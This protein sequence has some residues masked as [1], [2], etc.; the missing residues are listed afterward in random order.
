M[1][2]LRR[3]ANDQPQAARNNGVGHSP[4]VGTVGEVNRPKH[5]TSGGQVPGWLRAAFVILLTSLVILALAAITLLYF[6][7]THEADL[8][9]SKRQ[10]AIFL[11]NGQVYFGKI[12][13]L[14][15]Q[16]VNLT[17]IY[18]LN[19]QTNSDEAADKQTPNLSLVKL[20]CEL[21]G[22]QD[23]MIINRQQ[24]SF[25]ENLSNE[26]KVA[27]AISQWKSE[28]PEGQKCTDTSNST[29]QSPGAPT[30]T[31]APAPKPSDNTQN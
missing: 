8:I 14:N 1:D 11:T 23:Q 3:G 20:G 28:N 16:Y 7:K 13:G 31:T 5:T 19:S 6:G 25:W 10:Q 2:F 12:K 21:H 9:D 30:G 26:G 27:K 22:P 17:D 18:Y 15:P 4:T 29:Q 24:L